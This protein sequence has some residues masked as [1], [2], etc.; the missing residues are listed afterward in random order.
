MKTNL[1]ADLA[2]AVGAAT[3]PPPPS[4]NQKAV[5]TK[6]SNEKVKSC[7]LIGPHNQ[8]VTVVSYKK[9][10]NIFFGFKTHLL[11]LSPNYIKP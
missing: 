7:S 10:A 2:V 4:A 5:F 6:Q 1:S 8:N 11:S 3:A 9:P